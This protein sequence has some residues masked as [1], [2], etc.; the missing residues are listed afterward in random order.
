MTKMKKII[1]ICGLLFVFCSYSQAQRYFTR[2][3]EVKFFS[4]APLENIKA[5]NNKVLC[6][7]D[8]EKGQVAVDMLIK[9][10]EFPKKLMQEHFNENYM[11]S[12]R[13]PK[14]N[15]KGNFEVPKRLQ[16]MEEGEYLIPVIGQITIHGVKQKLDAPVNFIVKEGKVFTNFEFVIKVEDHKIKIPNLVVDNIAEEIL[17]SAS[18]QLESYKN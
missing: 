14:A 9:S 6:I 10:F 16:N 4:E 5:T 8:L 17:V 18:F 3:G 12:D 13:Y 1:A 15:Y 11:E 7:I 2:E